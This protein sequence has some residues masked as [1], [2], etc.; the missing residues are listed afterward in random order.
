MADVLAWYQASLA[1]LSAYSL[2]QAVA[3]TR[4]VS[5]LDAA[6]DEP[7]DVA[8]R[9]YLETLLPSHDGNEGIEAYL[10]RR[11]PTWRDR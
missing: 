8:E 1:P 9:H 5:G 7:L 4:R 10:E 3:V 2:R 11:A 6:L